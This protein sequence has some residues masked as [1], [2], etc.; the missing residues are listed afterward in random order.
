MPL[1][2]ERQAG[3]FVFYFV[4]EVEHCRVWNKGESC[5][6]EFTVR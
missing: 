5:F 6:R 3:E 4:N 2:G 1:Y